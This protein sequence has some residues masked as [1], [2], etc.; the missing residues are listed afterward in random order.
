M[1]SWFAQAKRWVVSPNLSTPGSP[2]H[3]HT[4]KH[5]AMEGGTRAL[6]HRSDSWMW[7]LAGVCT[8]QEQQALSSA[9]PCLWPPHCPT[10]ENLLWLNG[11]YLVKNTFPPTNIFLWHLNDYLYTKSW[12]IYLKKTP[13]NQ[14][15]NTNK[16]TPK[17]TNNHKNRQ[18][19]VSP[20]QHLLEP[21]PPQKVPVKY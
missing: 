12:V 5:V 13:Q 10:P 21:M 3:K 1:G 16:T 6:K 8:L 15:T 11:H 9:E 20:N 7:L 4:R 19:H 17:P 14:K 2:R 18:Q